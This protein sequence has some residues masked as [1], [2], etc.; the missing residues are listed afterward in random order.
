VSPV[1]APYRQ[2]PVWYWLVERVWRVERA[3]ASAKARRTDQDTPIRIFFVMVVFAAAFATLAVGA[4]T[5]ALS[6]A[7][8][9]ASYYSGAV[10]RADLT[11]RNGAILAVDLTHFAAYLD[12]REIWDIEETRRTLAA[13][14][15]EVPANRLERALRSK[16]RAYLVGDLT[17]EKKE[18]LHDLGL[19]GL[20]FE[21]EDHRVYPLGASA[22]HLVGTVDKG[23][24]GLSGAELALDD[25]IRE[26]GRRGRPV[27]LSI[28]NRVQAALEDE[29]M[30]AAIKHSVEGA[31]GIVTDVHTGEVLGLASYPDFDANQGGSAS[32]DATRNRAAASR[33]EMG[34][35]MKV[36]TLALAIDS[37]TANLGTVVD[38]VTPLRIGTRTIHDYHPAHKNLTVAEVFTTSSNMGSARLGLM[39]GVDNVHAY[40]RRFGLL[41]AAPIEL[42]ESA[43]PIIPR[44]W[45]QSSA[46]SVSFGHEL[47]LSPLAV[48]AGMDAVFNGGQYVPLTILKREPGDVPKGRRVVSPSTT[49]E[50]LKVMRMNVTGG[51]GTKADAPGLRVGGKTGSGEKPMNGGIARKALIASFAAIFPSDGPVEAKRYLVLIVMDT[52]KATPDTFGYATGG[53]TAAP[54]AGRVADR[55]APFLG[56]KRTPALPGVAT[57]VAAAQQTMGNEH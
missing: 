28:D 15:P 1:D 33:F 52:P 51:T 18:R 44:Q 37:G 20:T 8:E 7:D 29:V 47:S 54:A 38:T 12:P 35:V 13:A 43:S 27:A 9:R 25:L 2:L 39:A 34:S 57:K 11:D 16:R 36:F 32:P 4:A 6:N 21:E 55:I 17:P 30:K 22:S 48:V 45:T 23:G 41:E 14:L 42:R 40:F 19:P 26:E 10:E 53:W 49:M 31:I 24:Q 56:V 50:M 5:R 46:A 3:L